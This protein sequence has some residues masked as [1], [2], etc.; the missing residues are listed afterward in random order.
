MRFGIR[1]ARGIFL[2]IEL[3]HD[4]W[5]RMIG[6]SRPMVSRIMADL[7]NAGMIAREGKRYILLN[8][9]GLENRKTS[10]VPGFAQEDD[11][12]GFAKLAAASKIS[13]KKASATELVAQAPRERSG[14]RP[15]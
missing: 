2:S 14:S 8:G 13:L 9:G 4:E 3:G 7:I 6:S 10:L 11:Y 15:G 5:A 1:E 12:K